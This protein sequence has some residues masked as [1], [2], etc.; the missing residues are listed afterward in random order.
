MEK[1]IE[2]LKCK[3]CNKKLFKKDTFICSECKS[4]LCSKHIYFYVD[5]NNISITKNAKPHCKECYK[6]KFKNK[7]M[8]AVFL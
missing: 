5:G 2:K 7:I 1:M 4:I 6:I 8:G 3:E